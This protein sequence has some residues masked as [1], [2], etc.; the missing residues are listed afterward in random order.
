MGAPHSFVPY[1]W[2]QMWGQPG[3][4]HSLL[5]L[6]LDEDVETLDL[7]HELFLGH[8]L[9]TGRAAHP[10]GRN[11]DQLWGGPASRIASFS[12][13]QVGLGRL[14]GCLYLAPL[15]LSWGR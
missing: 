12:G 10:S 1:M 2:G 3:S 7:I 11:R 5:S 9:R 14:G 6:Y 15:L 13:T 4:Y 8:L